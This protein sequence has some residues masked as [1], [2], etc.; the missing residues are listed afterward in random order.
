MSAVF[1]V[2]D[3]RKWC[4]EFAV[5]RDLVASKSKESIDRLSRDVND[6]LCS[7]IERIN[8]IFIGLLLD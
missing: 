3:E 1:H 5:K 4:C 8:I 7:N 6:K 2:F